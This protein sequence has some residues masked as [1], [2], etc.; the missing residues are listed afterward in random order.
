MWTW[1]PVYLS[2][3]FHTNSLWLW[4]IIA[5]YKKICG[6]SL[7]I[8]MARTPRGKKHI[9]LWMKYRRVTHLI[10][11]IL[12]SVTSCSPL[13]GLNPLPGKLALGFGED[14]GLGLLNRCLSKSP[15]P[16][17]WTVLDT[18][19]ISG[20]TTKVRTQ[21]ITSGHTTKV[22]TQKIISFI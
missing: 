14:I 22:R 19:I 6:S 10:A 3:T 21:N 4:N 16:W 2:C 7:S 17:L 11:N 9:H 13:Q 1:M 12:W 8:I 18:R 5:S 20:C 15:N